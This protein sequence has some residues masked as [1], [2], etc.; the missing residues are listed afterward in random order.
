MCAWH[1][2]PYFPIRVSGTSQ[3]RSPSKT[4]ENQHVLLHMTHV[5]L[6]DV[7]R[8]TFPFR[9]FPDVGND[10]A[11]RTLNLTCVPTLTLTDPREASDSCRNPLP[12]C[13]QV[14]L[15]Y[16]THRATL[17]ATRRN[18]TACGLPRQEMSQFLKPIAYMGQDRLYS[19]TGVD[20]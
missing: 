13:S 11:I 2:G 18:D 6:Q 7:S 9:T 20:I 19:Q 15:Q 17:T 10:G 4:F 14:S 3:Q 8:L 12:S 1:A 5:S 16:S